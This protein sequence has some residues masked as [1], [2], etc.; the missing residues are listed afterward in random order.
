MRICDDKKGSPNAQG[1]HHFKV[2]EGLDACSYT[3]AC[4]EGV[5]M[6]LHV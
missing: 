4:G 6:K 1:S 5:S 3:P 2:L